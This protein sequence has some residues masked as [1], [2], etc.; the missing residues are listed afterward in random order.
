V[1]SIAATD[2]NAPPLAELLRGVPV[3]AGLPEE[4]AECLALL[5]KG[6][7]EHYVHDEYVNVGGYLIAV[8]TGHL[9]RP[10][11]TH[12]WAAGSILS[13]ES[14][15]DLLAGTARSDRQS[16]LYRLAAKDAAQLDALCPRI[17][18]ALRQL[19]DPHPLMSPQ[20][21]RKAP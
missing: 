17:A 1:Y 15:S 10:D 9:R 13:P 18:T 11:S 8:C 3:F 21:E 19:N 4:E 12:R 2:P 14:S 16:L 7:I 20:T 6:W 5:R